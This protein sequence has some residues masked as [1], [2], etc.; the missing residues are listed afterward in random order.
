MAR[1][2]HY[3]YTK[4]LNS[5]ITRQS[6]IQEIRRSRLSLALSCCRCVGYKGHAPI[7]Y[8]LLPRWAR[9]CSRNTTSSPGWEG[10]GNVG[11]VSG[12]E[13]I[14]SPRGSRLVRPKED[15]ARDRRLHRG[16]QGPHSRHDNGREEEDRT[17][18]PRDYA[19]DG[20]PGGCGEG[21]WRCLMS[22]TTVGRRWV[23]ARLRTDRVDNNRKSIVIIY[24]IAQGRG[25][26]FPRGGNFLSE[27]GR[28]SRLGEPN[29]Q[30]SRRHIYKTS[31]TI[32]LSLGHAIRTGS[33]FGYC[34]VVRSWLS[35]VQSQ[36]HRKIRR[37]KKSDQWKKHVTIPL[38]VRP[39]WRFDFLPK[40]ITTNNSKFTLCGSS[41][42]PP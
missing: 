32:V 1:R 10:G 18:T 3:N 19:L 14:R 38:Y 6:Y 26:E 31:Q 33:E 37:E 13:G 15:D 29:R 9:T 4:H 2:H 12:R 28:V 42:L 35:F 30:G 25:R 11:K 7:V 24:V 8:Q 17:V 20:Y 22:G 21:G 23:A 36:W 41:L 39:E 34:I 5:L 16:G 40:K 27:D